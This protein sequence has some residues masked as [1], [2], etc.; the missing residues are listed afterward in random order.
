VA[1][2]TNKWPDFYVLSAKLSPLTRARFARAGCVAKLA[3]APAQL[4]KRMMLSI[5]VDVERK[6]I[7]P[8]MPRTERHLLARTTMLREDMPAPDLLWQYAQTMALVAFARLELPPRPI[9][10]EGQLAAR[11]NIV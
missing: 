3:N 10:P 5:Y 11:L 4:P 1:S 6:P 2:T 7:P 9:R 8:R